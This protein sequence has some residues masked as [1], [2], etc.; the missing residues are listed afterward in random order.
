MKNISD[1]HRAQIEGLWNEGNTA[2]HISD[3]TGVPVRLV[4]AYIREN[5]S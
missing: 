3:E 1:F 5:F 2:E 4:R